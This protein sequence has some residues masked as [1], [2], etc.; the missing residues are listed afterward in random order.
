MNEFPNER[1]NPA[2]QLTGY[3][4]LRLL[5]PSAELER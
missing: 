2:L 3:S 1:A 5:P 4:K